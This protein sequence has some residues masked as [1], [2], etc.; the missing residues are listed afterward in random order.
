M[1]TSA[2]VDTCCPARESEALSAM[3]SAVLYGLFCERRGGRLRRLDLDRRRDFAEQLK[4]IRQ[5]L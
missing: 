1:V 3:Q 5:A 2:Q 4:R